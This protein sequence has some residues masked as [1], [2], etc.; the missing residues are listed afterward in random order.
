MDDL[1][2]A[3]AL[4][5][6][7]SRLPGEGIAA[8][9]ARYPQYRADLDPLLR[10]AAGLET[11]VAHIAPRPAAR[12]AIRARILAAAVP[13]ASGTP[14]VQVQ[15]VA[16]GVVTVGPHRLVALRG[17][18]D[19]AP[20]PAS[21]NGRHGIQP[22]RAAA[23][24]VLLLGGSLA[25][26]YPVAAASLPGDP[27][28]G[29]K[30][31]LESLRVTLAGSPADRAPLHLDLAAQRAAEVNALVAKGRADLAPTALTGM[32]AHTEAGLAALDTLAPGQQSSLLTRL[33]QTNDQEAAA[34]ALA[35]PALANSPAGGAAYASAGSSLD[36]SRSLLARL[37]A[38]TPTAVPTATEEAVDATVVAEETALAAATAIP[39]ATVPQVAPPPVAKRTPGPKQTP[40]GQVARTP[41]PKE[42]PPGQVGRTP[43]PQHTPGPPV[44]SGVPLSPSPTL[45]A[46]PEPEHTP[47]PQKTPPGRVDHTPVPVQTPPGQVERTPKPAK[48]PPGQ[49][50]RTP[51]P[52]PTEGT[53]G[54]GSPGA[55]PTANT[56]DDNGNS[57]TKPPKNK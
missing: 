56:G 25:F 8:C 2:L 26:S 54:N 40:P 38:P 55:E 7:L 1:L 15:P 11:T 32:A 24:V 50:D 36:A 49:V 52:R 39:V 47:G 29:E 53:G 3:Q 17:G 37:A 31:A 27:L 18:K 42:T 5:D 57:N 22:W 33:G 14:P 13:A 20:A 30:L 4:D 21:A 51:Q 16:G 46:T 35:Q 12:S 19:A 23:A 48:T 45:T 43:G 6:C 10:V 44:I 41:K 34:L 28:Y 9:L